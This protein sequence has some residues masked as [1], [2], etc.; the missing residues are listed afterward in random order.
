M[1]SSGPLRVGMTSAKGS[2]ISPAQVSLSV[3]GVAHAV[4]ASTRLL[5][6]LRDQL[7]LTG[8][9]PGC[10]EGV[11]GACTVLL[12]GAPVRA[13]QVS[14][15]EVAGGELTTV[16][17]LTDGAR[18]HPL[19]RAFAREGAAQCGYCTPGLVL[20]GTALLASHPSPSD[21]DID[22]A[23]A[24]HIC[25]CGGYPRIRRA[26]RSAAL[27]TDP[28]AGTPAPQ[29][30]LAV[31]P[32]ERD[33]EPDRWGP[34]EPGT[35]FFRPARPWDLASPRDR[36]WFGA[37]G[38][39]L[40]VAL[41]PDDDT[42]SRVTARGAWLHISTGGLV[43]AFTG[44]V[45]VGQDNRTA[46]RLLVA[47]ELG[48]ELGQVRLVM[49]DTDLCPHDRGTFGSRS[50]PDAGSVLRRTAT[51]A[52]SLEP[53]QAGEQRVALVTGDPVLSDPATWSQAGHP[54]RAPGTVACVT[55]RRRFVSDLSCPGLRHGAIL[56]PPVPGATLRA[57]D[58]SAL[59]DHPGVTLVRTDELIGVVAA[60]LATARTAIG[61]LEAAASW[62]LPNSPS[63]PD[64]ASYLRAH[65]LQ[66]G[67]FKS[68][69]GSAATALEVAAVRA[70]ATYTAAYIA[71]A[72][73]ETRVGLARWDGDRVTVWTGT[74]T[75]F[76]VRAEVA[77]ALSV[78]E[79][80]V[81][82]IVPATGGAFGGK[83]AAGIAVE[84]AVL[85]RHAGAPVRLAWSRA[86]EFT[87][88]TLRRAAV[89]DV[90]AGAAATGELSGW[91]FL[92][93]NA[94]TAGIS[95]PYRVSDV[96]LEYQ[97]AHS[98]LPQGSYRALAAT[99]SNF[100]RESTIDEL[101]AAL[102][103]DPVEF[104]LRNLA[105]ERLADVLRAVADRVSWPDLHADRAERQAAIPRVGWGIACGLDK[106][107]R[108][109]T[110]A[111]VAVWPAGEV[112]VTRLVSGY[113][114][115]TIVNPAAVTGQVEGAAVMALG[116]AL[117][118]AITFT[119]GAITNA[120]F[121]AYRV[122]RMADV[123]PIDVILIDRPDLPSAGAG[124]TP[125]IA[126]APAIAG[127]IFDA[128]GCRLR[129]LPLRLQ[130]L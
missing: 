20:A 53:V 37:L 54:H 69:E 123:P 56:R 110:A 85:A 7:G 129:S 3:N 101:A 82:V 36:D 92:N 42:A 87:A 41:E 107:G 8:A 64:L 79:E 9:K 115:G 70:E 91:T 2:H 13:C 30:A 94:G 16:E 77:A 93:L 22:S 125:M 78:G 25:R 90:V 32:S 5:D 98:P 120:S 52:R 72:A 121:S 59:T 88:G 130:T 21:A 117:F 116:G 86:E 47:E 71:P 43:T 35:P 11:C 67:A 27:V 83:H 126:V 100:A 15:D 48:V 10:G 95:S 104:R 18:L 38:D 105:D 81:R 119:G 1:G 80:S 57:L 62:D 74:Q 6:V 68:S 31:E 112:K 14:A 99:A 113:E 66:A 26:L 45:D 24:G 108:I 97:P 29:P 58:Q 65:P 89:I 17:G 46:L 75:P 33:P 102:G 111:Q 106:D 124:E 39:G 51:Y 103:A 122:P 40:A 19:Q 55:G 76:P 28:D 84:A 60:D 96:R 128:T 118:E 23:L 63:D 44:K 61:D 50:M 73:L 127:A 49:G 4:P 109:V 34:P 12:D 114:C